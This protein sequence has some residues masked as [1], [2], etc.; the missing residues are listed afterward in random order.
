[1]EWTIVGSV[2]VALGLFIGGMMV[3]MGGMF[4]LAARGMKK[5]LESGSTPKCPMPGC[6]CHQA[7]EKATVGKAKERTDGAAQ[8][9]HL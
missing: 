7:F 3:L 2:A 6:P 9:I 1:M 4:T 8:P 5:Q